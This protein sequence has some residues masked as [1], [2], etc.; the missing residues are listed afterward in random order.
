MIDHEWEPAEGPGGL[1]RCVRCGLGV[2]C[3]EAPFRLEAEI[4]LFAMYHGKA[5]R[6]AFLTSDCDLELVKEVMGS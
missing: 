1:F 3:D 4:G 2:R 6:V 5:V